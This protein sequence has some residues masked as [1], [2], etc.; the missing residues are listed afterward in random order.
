MDE[1]RW[2]VRYRDYFWILLPAT[3]LM[4]GYFS[5]L[6]QGV[7]FNSTAEEIDRDDA[8]R[9]STV[10]LSRQDWTEFHLSPDAHSIRVMTNGA[11]N[12]IQLPKKNQSDP[13]TGWR[14]S[15]QYQLLDADGELIGQHTYESRT[16]VRQLIDKDQGTLINPLMFGKTKRIATQTRFIQI[17][18]DP[19]RLKPAVLRIRAADSDPQISEI[20]ARVR[21]KH[22]RPHFDQPSTWRQIRL[23]NRRKMAKYFVFDQKFLTPS[24]RASLLRWQWLPAPTLNKTTL[25]HLYFI[26]EIDDQEVTENIPTSANSLPATRKITLPLPETQGK[27]SLLLKRPYESSSNP[28]YLTVRFFASDDSP[29][30]VWERT[31]HESAKEFSFPVSGGLVEFESTHDARWSAT[32]THNQPDAPS[33]KIHD[34]E[35]AFGQAVDITSKTGNLRVYL[36][37]DVPVSYQVSH[38]QD[39]PTPFRITCRLAFGDV[40]ASDKV[41]AS[42]RSSDGSHVGMD[43][44]KFLHWTWLDDEDQVIESGKLSVKPEI[45]KYDQLLSGGETHL[46]SEYKRFYFSIPPEVSKIQ[47]KSDN[48]PFLVNASVR[49]NHLPVMTRLPEDRHPFERQFKP[50]RKWYSLQPDQNLQLISDNR[51]FVLGTQ[52]RPRDIDDEELVGPRE[53][54]FRRYEPAGQWIGR[55]LLAP[56]VIESV[57]TQTNRSSSFYQLNNGQSY[58]VE[59]YGLNVPASYRLIYV[60]SAAIEGPLVVRQNGRIVQ[61]EQ[62]NSS[63]GTVRLKL[64][65]FDDTSTITLQGPPNIRMFLSGGKVENAKRFLKRTASKL[66]NG[67]LEFEHVKTTPLDEVLTL[68]IYRKF[69]GQQRCKFSVKIEANDEIQMQKSGPVESLTSLHQIYDLKS[70]PQQQSAILIGTD[71]ELDV[72][73]R[74]FVRLGPDLPPG[75]YTIKTERVD[76]QEGGFV[77]LYQSIPMEEV[78]QVHTHQIRTQN[79]EPKTKN[80]KQKLFQNLKK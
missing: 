18:I 15:I 7:G 44:L 40:F 53:F 36:A 77:L 23:S 57:I 42:S 6:L 58:T 50:H 10:L 28:I 47:F 31:L 70:S 21:T 8:K 68:L 41:I 32:W 63:R 26:G 80:A 25:R 52:T 65:P 66:E 24:E 2:A 61:R 54:L 76:Q 20:V 13:R 72:E 69:S 79:D 4:S 37:D 64:E 17:P 45:S 75:R 30:K 49:P 5:G 67:K 46:V 39:Q 16:R 78:Q 35:V 43:E 14:Y 22:E 56:A 38:Y 34:T 59:D 12:T 1:S 48:V 27:F 33:I 71:A 51:S 11:L 55:Q 62:L 3:L 60:A 73:H 29:C 74:C 19:D 9:V